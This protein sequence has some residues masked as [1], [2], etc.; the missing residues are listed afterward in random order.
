MFLTQHGDVYGSATFTGRLRRLGSLRC[1]DGWEQMDALLRADGDR[2]VLHGN[3]QLAST[4]GATLRLEA[5]PAVIDLA[6]RDAQTGARITASRGVE[7]TAD[8]GLYALTTAGEFRVD[9]ETATRAA[10]PP[11]APPRVTLGEERLRSALLE[12]YEVA[13]RAEPGACPR[14]VANETQYQTPGFRVAPSGAGSLAARWAAIEP[15]PRAPLGPPDTAVTARDPAVMVYRRW[16][17]DGGAA[18]SIVWRSTD[19]L[20]SYTS[21]MDGV[22][23]PVDFATDD[24]FW[25][26]FRVEQ[27]SLARG[28]GVDD[29]VCVER[30]CGVEL[31]RTSDSDGETSLRTSICFVTSTPRPSLRVDTGQRIQ[32]APAVLLPWRSPG[33]E[34][35]P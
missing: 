31:S 7:Q 2:V 17:E 30:V 35:G 32:T 1:S 34:E 29:P 12:R 18:R 22:L 13:P 19:A 24:E 14:P 23:L 11:P 33:D 27:V 4:D 3:G 15:G 28:P 5:D 26:D 9:E 21:R 25:R 20:G 6:W 10:S 8:G 16:S